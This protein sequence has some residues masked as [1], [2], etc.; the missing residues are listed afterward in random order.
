[1]EFVSNLTWITRVRTLWF[2][3]ILYH[4]LAST[5]RWWFEVLNFIK[6]FLSICGK[7]INVIFIKIFLKNLLN[8]PFWRVI[9][10]TRP[11]LD[12]GLVTF[13]LQLQKSTLHLLYFV[14][15]KYLKKPTYLK[16]FKHLQSKI[17][18]YFPF[19]IG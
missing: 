7:Y 4:L 16:Y 12:L 13:V 18:T 19:D 6:I 10:S 14:Q 8:I 3:G 2:K 11:F 17:L 5:G 15:T 1:M 9:N